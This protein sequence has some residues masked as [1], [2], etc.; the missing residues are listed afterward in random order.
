[1][2][3][4]HVVTPQYGTVI[5]VCDFGQGPTEYGADVVE[6]QAATKREAVVAG[7]KRMLKG[8]YSSRGFKWCIDQR[9][10]GRNPFAG[11]KAYEFVPGESSPGE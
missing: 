1:M 7:V 3:W 2:K 9:C 8:P 11:V 4:W 6:V 10:D 5:P